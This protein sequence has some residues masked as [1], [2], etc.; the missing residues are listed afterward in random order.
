[1]EKRYMVMFIAAGAAIGVYG[2]LTQQILLAALLLLLVILGAVGVYIHQRSTPS[3]P[4]IW[5]D[6]WSAIIAGAA[7]GY[8]FSIMHVEYLLWAVAI[9][10]LFLIQQSLARIEKRL[11]KLEKP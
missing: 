7:I 6:G 4:E 1:M 10:A 9:A 5:N 3:E 8:V 2:A 11:E